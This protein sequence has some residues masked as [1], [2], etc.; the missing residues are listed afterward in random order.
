MSTRPSLWRKDIL[1]WTLYD[2]ANTIFAMNIVSRY[3]KLYIVEDL[4]RD[5]RYF[6]IPYS[7]SMLL[8]AVLLPAL[9]AVSDQQGKKKYFLF[10]FTITCCIATGV[11]AY[12]PPEAFI[13]LVVMVIISNFSYEAGQ[14]FYNALLYSVTDGRHARYVSGVGVALGYVGS[15]LGMILVLPFVTGSLFA[16]DVPFLEG[17]GRVGSFVPTAA[18]F[19][20]LSI[21]TFLWVKEKRIKSTG[22]GLAK[23][24]RDVWL[25]IK[26][27][28]K[29]PGVLRFLVSDYFFEDAVATV[30]INIGL[31]SAVV[32]GFAEDMITLFLIVSTVTAVIGSWVIG[33]LAER[34]SLKTLLNYVVIG[35]IIS[36]LVFVFVSSHLV[37]WVFGS[38]V[39]ILLGGL[40][41]TTRPMLAELV[42]EKDLG[43]FF[44]LFS[45]SGRAAAVVGPLVWTAIVYLFNSERLLGRFVIETLSIE[46]VEQLPY[47]VALLS[48]A[49]MMVIGLYLFRK[50]PSGREESGA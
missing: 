15:V 17:G 4:G 7:I 3:L 35:W 22:G 5:D 8:A 28:K 26:D 23:A 41:T 36:L 45:L 18:L 31:Y 39:G 47:K 1:G 37:I 40:W 12:V 42:P 49:V 16:W 6:D 2:F 38:I 46:E 34:Y 19:L 29:Y 21:P 13:L 33:K 32:I 27:T 43:R 20:L 10:L 24:Y 48:L 14:P 9:G 44:G 50:V 11:M 25:A 30:V